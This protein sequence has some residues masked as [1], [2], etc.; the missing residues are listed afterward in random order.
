LAS[1]INHLQLDYFQAAE[2]GTMRLLYFFA[3]DDSAFAQVV[4]TEWR[5]AALG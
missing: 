4:P 1:A 2:L 3:G 5:Y